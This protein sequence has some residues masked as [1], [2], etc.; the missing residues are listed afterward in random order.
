MQVS[1]VRGHEI[2]NRLG[3]CHHR[4]SY[5]SLDAQFWLTTRSGVEPGNGGCR[6]VEERALGAKETQEVTVRS[7]VCLGTE[8]S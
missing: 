6:R 7:V 2:A 5:R 4:G 1:W 8:I 3:E